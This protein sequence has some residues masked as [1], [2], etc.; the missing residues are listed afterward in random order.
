ML[1]RKPN[2]THLSIPPIIAQTLEMAAAAPEPPLPLISSINPLNYSSMPI[3]IPMRIPILMPMLISNG[4]NAANRPMLQD[5]VNEESVG[6]TD[7][8]SA[9]TE[10]SNLLPMMT[11][12]SN[13]PTNIPHG[14]STNNSNPIIKPFETITAFRPTFLF[15]NPLYQAAI[16]NQYNTFRP[17]GMYNI[18]Y[19]IQ[20][21]T[22]SQNRKISSKLKRRPAKPMKNIV[23]NIT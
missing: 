5:P 9:V 18:F 4:N 2:A 8:V 15:G 12:N 7:K 20:Q 23:I 14:G 21:N 3:P 22:S 17:Y 13:Q 6:H 19:P 1:H 16:Y 10:F 11:Q